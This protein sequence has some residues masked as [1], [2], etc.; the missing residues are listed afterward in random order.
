MFVS[1]TKKISIYQQLDIAAFGLLSLL[2]LFS[3][4]LFEQDLSIYLSRLLNRTA[5][6]TV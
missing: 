4:V 3:H 5:T 6:M 1:A 2:Y